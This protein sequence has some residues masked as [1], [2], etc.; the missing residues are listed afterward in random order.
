MVPCKNEIYG[1]FIDTNFITIEYR[2]LM[3]LC[4][5]HWDAYFEYP[6]MAIILKKEEGE[7]L[8]KVQNVMDS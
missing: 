7:N 4:K 3:K 2:K 5:Y 6:R 8:L 1:Y